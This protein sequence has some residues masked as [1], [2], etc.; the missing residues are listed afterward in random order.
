MEYSFFHKNYSGVDV[1]ECPGDSDAPIIIFCHGYGSSADNLTFF[2]NTCNFSGL[3]PTWIFPQGI[4]KLPSDLGSGYAWFPL[5]VPLFHELINTSQINERT[6]QQYQELFDVDFNR[7]REALENMISDLGRNKSEI[8]IGGFSQGAMITTHL[9][10]SSPSAYCGAIICSGALILKK[11]WDTLVQNC[12]QTPFI[13]SH[14]HQDQILPYY[15]G[16]S[17]FTL[18][19]SQLC[20]EF[21]PFIGGHEIPLQMTQK[22]CKKVPIWFKKD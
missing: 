15:L 9:I 3:R 7:P 21:V 19:S 4:E 12:A 2:P 14:G 13:Q 1:I 22:M 6:R 8:I 17:L 16:D 10:L 11:Y 5:N 20:G 18:L